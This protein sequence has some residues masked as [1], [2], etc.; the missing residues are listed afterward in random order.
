MAGEI[1]YKEA[2]AQRSRTVVGSSMALQPFAFVRP[3]ASGQIDVAVEDEVSEEDA[4]VQGE[5]GVSGSGGP[6]EGGMTH[7]STAAIIC[8]L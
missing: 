4:A 3:F 2:C 8:A 6:V 5:R 1:L 7:N